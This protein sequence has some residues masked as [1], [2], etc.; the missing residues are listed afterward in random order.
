MLDKRLVALVALAAN[1]QA[2]A[3][4]QNE[5]WESQKP[6][7]GTLGW[8]GVGVGIA[9]LVIVLVLGTYALLV[10]VRGSAKKGD[11]LEMA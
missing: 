11:A 6:A 8:V 9:G 7:L 2:V 1:C 4:E 5:M 3:A 10:S